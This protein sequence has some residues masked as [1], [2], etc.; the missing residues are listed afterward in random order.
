[1]VPPVP[2]DSGAAYFIILQTRK[3]QSPPPILL[4]SSAILQRATLWFLFPVA[5]RALSTESAPRCRFT[6]RAVD[7]H[8]LHLRVLNK[9][10]CGANYNTSPAG[11][12]SEHVGVPSATV[13]EAKSQAYTAGFDLK[14]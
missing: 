14:C 2:G 11:D 7:V 5:A 12:S 10:H 9:V 6:G 4:A 8:V 13:E 1:M 3:T